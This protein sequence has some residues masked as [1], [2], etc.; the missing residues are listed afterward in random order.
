MGSWKMLTREALG[1]GKVKILSQDYSKLQS[2]LAGDL[3]AAAATA[4]MAD[5]GKRKKLRVSGSE[6][7]SAVP[8]G[9]TVKLEQVAMSKLKMGDILCVN[10]GQGPELR[11]FVKLKI[12]K[13]DTYL[14]TANDELSVKEPLPNSAV[15]GK[16]VEAEIAGRKWDPSKENPFRRFWSKLTEYGTHK[17]FGIG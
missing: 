14:L 16:V 6:L 15:I 13:T 1:S 4:A 7:A 9:A 8:A 2:Q 5:G 17:P 11:R 3:S 10:L 12:A